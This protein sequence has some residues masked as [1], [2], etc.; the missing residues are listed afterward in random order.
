MHSN[1]TDESQKTLKYQQ[2]KEYIIGLAVEQKWLPGQKLPTENDLVQQFNISRTTVRQAFSDLEQEGIISRRRGQGT[3]F[4][5]AEKNV[6]RHFLVGVTVSAPAYIYNEITQ[7]AETVLVA[8]GYHLVI[9]RSALNLS[10]QKAGGGGAS[11]WMPDGHLIEPWDRDNS[12]NMEEMCREL[13]ARNTPFVLMNWIT[14]DPDVSFVAPDDEEAG[15]RAYR[16]L[17]GLGHEKIAY[18][19]MTGHQ[20]SSVRLA[21]L[22]EAARAEGR[23][24]SERLVKETTA[25]IMNSPTLPDVATREL[26]TLGPERPTAIFY[27]NDEAASKGYQVIREAG[28]SIPDDVSVIGFDDSR[29]CQALYPALSSFAHPKKRVGEMAARILLDRIENPDTFLP[30]HLLYLCKLRERGSVRKLH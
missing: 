30:V 13:K 7:G 29:I 20:P 10:L 22:R 17:R 6:G 25:V 15:A 14:Q 23:S 19:G 16:Y 8:A 1:N 12:I 24:L 4:T 9:G 2:I 11:G 27:F 28:L 5:G 21:G 3:F 26:L 18:V